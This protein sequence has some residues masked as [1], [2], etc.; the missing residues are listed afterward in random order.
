MKNTST[1][2]PNDKTTAAIEEDRKIALENAEKGCDSIQALKNA[3]Y[4]ADVDIRK[5]KHS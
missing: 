5:E 2:I 3:L 4:L 1:N